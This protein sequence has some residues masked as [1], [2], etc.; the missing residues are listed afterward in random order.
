MG[1][2]YV[3][4]CVQVVHVSLC[5]GMEQYF[6]KFVDTVSQVPQHFVAWIKKEDHLSGKPAISPLP[7]IAP[8]LLKMIAVKLDGPSMLHFALCCSPINQKLN[9]EHHWIADWHHNGMR[10]PLKI[11]K[12]YVEHNEALI[13]AYGQYPPQQLL[14]IPAFAEPLKNQLTDFNYC[15]IQTRYW[16]GVL[17]DINSYEINPKH[18]VVDKDTKKILEYGPRS[19]IVNNMMHILCARAQHPEC[20]KYLLNQRADANCVLLNSES[21]IQG[22]INAFTNENLFIGN[23]KRC[24]SI[25]NVLLNHNADI[26]YK[27]VDGSNY[28]HRVSICQDGHLLLP[29]FIKQGVNLNERNNMG[30]TPLLVL[31]ECARDILLISEEYSEESRPGFLESIRLLTEAKADTTMQNNKNESLFDLLPPRLH[32]EVQAIIDKKVEDQQ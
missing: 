22:A 20:V 21:P 16:D 17:F 11:A 14:H 31:A 30:N 24:T 5:Y 12:E 6:N 7:S 25:I 18:S 1:L 2:R 13:A 23:V 19:S 28:L 9:S 27:K 8:E 10:A 32:Q 4:L 29:C 15:R 3:L 26:H